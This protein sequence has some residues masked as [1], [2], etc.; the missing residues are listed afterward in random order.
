MAASRLCT[1][2]KAWLS[3]RFYLGAG[4]AQRVPTLWSGDEF[5]NKSD[6]ILV[7]G[8]RCCA[9]EFWIVWPF[10]SSESDGTDRMTR[11]ARRVPAGF[12]GAALTGRRF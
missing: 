1:G 9:A 10:S 12:G 4:R 11:R 5:S 8:R 2:P 3:G 6:G 7:V